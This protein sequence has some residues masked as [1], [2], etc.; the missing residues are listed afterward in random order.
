[1]VSLALDESAGIVEYDVDLASSK[2]T[3]TYDPSEVALK[4]I[5][6]AITKR[7]GYDNLSV[8][9]PELDGR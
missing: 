7:T 3:V 8:E 5:L 1:M 6:S 4:A 9:R 2:A